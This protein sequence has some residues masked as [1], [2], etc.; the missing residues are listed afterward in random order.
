MLSAHAKGDDRAAWRRD[1][2]LLL[3]MLKERLGLELDM[4]LSAPFLAQEVL[5]RSTHRLELREAEEGAALLALAF[6]EVRSG[7][8]A[9]ALTFLASTRKGCGSALL[10][11][12]EH[13]PLFGPSYLTLRS[14][15]K[16]LPFYLKKG[17]RTFD[18][19]CSSGYFSGCTDERANECLRVACG[20]LARGEAARCAV[21]RAYAA[22]VGKGWVPEEHE[23][24]MSFPL[25]KMRTAPAP[26]AVPVGRRSAR[27]ALRE[28]AWRSAP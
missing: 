27:L 4:R 3:R 20:D 21:V 19:N 5:G 16:A 2:V 7:A 10:A 6:V 23:G 11:H 14:T 17:Y 1:S 8:K 15:L 25:A 9:M 24:E 26:Q 22:L 28:S 18:Y 13:T 12:I